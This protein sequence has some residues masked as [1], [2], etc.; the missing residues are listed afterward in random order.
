MISLNDLKRARTSIDEPFPIPTIEK[1]AHRDASFP[2]RTLFTGRNSAS[3][4][5]VPLQYVPVLVVFLSLNS[6]YYLHK[7]NNYTFVQTAQLA[8][9]L[10]AA[11]SSVRE[12]PTTPTNRQIDP[13][14]E[15]A[16]AADATASVFMPSLS[17]STG[18]RPLSRGDGLISHSQASLGSEIEERTSRI[19]GIG[20]PSMN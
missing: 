19:P 1:D 16:W 10:L 7:L 9:S 12:Q 13:I 8:H 11:T 15:I 4:N 18:T 6:R 5:S 3:S 17:N 14:R 20:L 2:V